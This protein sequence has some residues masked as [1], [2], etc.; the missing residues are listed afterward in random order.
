[1][2]DN[3]KSLREVIRKVIMKE[4][5]VVQF[6]IRQDNK[7]GGA[8]PPETEKPSKGQTPSSRPAATSSQVGGRVARRAAAGQRP[9]AAPAGNWNAVGDSTRPSSNPGKGTVSDPPKT[10]PR[11]S[12]GSTLRA[13]LG[14]VAGAALGGPATAAAAILN[15]T[16]VAKSELS[17]EVAAKQQQRLQAFNAADLRAG[18]GGSSPSTSRVSGSTPASSGSSPQEKPKVDPDAA[19]AASDPKPDEATSNRAALGLATGSSGEAAKE[20]TPAA[21]PKAAGFG[22]SG[23]QSSTGPV[24]KATGFDGDKKQTFGQAFAAARKEAGG[25]GGKFTW[26]GKEYQTNVAG[27][28]YRP[29]GQLKTVGEKPSSSSTPSPVPL[30]KAPEASSTSATSMAPSSFKAEAPKPAEQPA[31]SNDSEE[32]KKK[33]TTRS[34]VGGGLGFGLRG[35]TNE[36]KEPKMSSMV[37]AFL[38]LHSKQTYNNIFSEAK[39]MKEATD[40]EVNAI[41]KGAS[42]SSKSKT[43]DISGAKSAKDSS[44]STSEKGSGERSSKAPETKNTESK[45]DSKPTIK[46]TDQTISGQ[47]D[48]D[49][50]GRTGD[51]AKRYRHERDTDPRKSNAASTASSTKEPPAASN[52]DDEEEKA[53]QELQRQ[54]GPDKKVLR[55]G[56]RGFVHDGKWHSLSKLEPDE[57]YV[58]S[59]DDEEDDRRALK[60]W[61]RMSKDEDEMAKIKYPGS[62]K[63]GERSA[64]EMLAAHRAQRAARRAAEAKNKTNEGYVF[65]EAKGSHPATTKE[66]SLAALG[67]PKNKITHKDVLIG[68]GVL[69]KESSEETAGAVRRNGRDVVSP[70]AP[71]GSGY[72]KEGPSDKER[73]QLNKMIDKI[74]KE[75]PANEEVEFSEAELAHIAAI[76]EISV[77]ASP[78]ADDYTGSNHGVS[79]RDLT[80][81]TMSEEEAVKRGRGRP[82]GKY[83]SYKRKDTAGAEP[84][85]HKAEPKNLVAQNPR[86]YNR[87]GKNLVD[88]EHP[89][90][91]G[92]KRTVPAKHYNDF[93]SSYLNAEKPAEK[94]RMHD[95]MVSRVFGN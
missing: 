62:V 18:G 35:G 80:D 1:M 36:Q 41:I 2:S 75:R 13:G 71:G 46:P 26:Q 27:E 85:E 14:R 45:P 66:K 73:S 59:D 58:P 20:K 86:T 40:D 7:P 5:E 15:P 6:P 49:V 39:K 29:A 44:S 84:E 28:K 33:T 50:G 38:K 43:D 83:G 89:S 65:G 61:Q 34:G 32:A 94:Q 24:A 69:A 77:P 68:R 92:V 63:T 25:A 53:R 81:E 47:D 90:K 9:S 60:A 51:S 23:A 30:P 17:P 21:A 54:V 74:Q 31:P 76:M 22:L 3:Y 64:D 11:P 67:H 12:V 56:E 48:D 19:F 52:D 82:A 91:P 88:L 70:T 4:A 10:T 72:K 87:D 55:R 93:R 8:R 57:R 42:G 78:V 95:S 16:T 37:E 79:K